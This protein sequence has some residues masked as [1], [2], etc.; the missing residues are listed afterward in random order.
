MCPAAPSRPDAPLDAYTASAHAPRDED[1]NDLNS[2]AF[3]LQVWHCIPSGQRNLST[4]SLSWTVLQARAA[5][6]RPCGVYESV[7]HIRCG[8]IYHV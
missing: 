4:M 3:E 8:K 6:V 2:Y 5:R 7:I 1:T